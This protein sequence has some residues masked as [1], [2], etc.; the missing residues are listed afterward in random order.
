MRDA[1]HIQEDRRFNRVLMHMSAHWNGVLVMLVASITAGTLLATVEKAKIR[2]P[3]ALACFFAFC[4]A[5]TLYF[6][7]RM[8]SFADEINEFAGVDSP[9]FPKNFEAGAFLTLGI[10]V[11]DIALLFW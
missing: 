1:S 10:Y 6:L 5:L 9:L 11:L 2:H 3:W 8:R 7:I 4:L